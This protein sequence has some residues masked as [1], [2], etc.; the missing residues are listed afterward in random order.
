M[1]VHCIYVYIQCIY[2]YIHCT[3]VPSIVCIYQC[4]ICHCILSCTAFDRG[5]YNAIILESTIVYIQGYTSK[6]PTK[7][8]CWDNW[9]KHVCTLHIHVHTVYIHV[10]TLYMGT[11]YCMHIYHYCV[12]HCM[13]V[14]T[15]LSYRNLQLC[16]YRDIPPI[17]P[18][19]MA[20]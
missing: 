2:M 15:M 6:M 9:L 5:M 17:Y 8:C 18:L 13:L 12:C 3:W 7:I 20:F 4:G 1:Y 10:H 11:M 16:T 14:Y 19:R